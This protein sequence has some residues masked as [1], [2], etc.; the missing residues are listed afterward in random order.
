[1]D[2]RRWY[3]HTTP[4]VTTPLQ[5]KTDLTQVQ[6]THGL[7]SS[8]VGSSKVA[9]QGKCSS[10]HKTG[11]KSKLQRPDYTTFDRSLRVTENNRTACENHPQ[12]RGKENTNPLAST[13]QNIC[14]TQ[15]IPSLPTLSPRQGQLLTV[16][17]LIS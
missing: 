15:E 5:R 13:S 14:S 1:M 12:Y 16:L 10:C 9:W 3:P 6:V 7:K 4:F 11:H 17:D 8:R 2:S